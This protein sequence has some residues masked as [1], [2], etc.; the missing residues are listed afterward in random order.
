MVLTIAFVYVLSGCKENTKSA[1]AYHDN[2]YQSVDTII[3][4]VFEL[5]NHLQDDSVS[6]AKES[7]DKLLNIVTTNNKLVEEKGDFNGDDSFRQASLNLLHFYKDYTEKDFNK[8]LQIATKDS[9]TE[10]DQS[11]ITAIIDRF[12]DEESKY[13]DAFNKA[14]YDFG[15]KY[16]IYKAAAN[17]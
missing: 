14:S 7:Y 13:I 2:I 16:K 4:S 10:Q 6:M 8:A 3:N 15:D 9:L 5:D 17:K 1:K 11:G 12:Y